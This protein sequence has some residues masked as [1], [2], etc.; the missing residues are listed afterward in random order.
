MFKGYRWKFATEVYT[1][2]TKL[3]KRQDSNDTP[4]PIMPFAEDK[5]VIVGQ[6]YKHAQEYARGIH[7]V[8]NL[9]WIILDMYL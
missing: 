9:T 5:H 1:E 3:M 8:C 4:G 7:L 6:Q 2:K